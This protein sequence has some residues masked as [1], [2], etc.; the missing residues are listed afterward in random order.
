M[1]SATWSQI[2]SHAWRGEDGGDDGR[3][4]EES[5]RWGQHCK[6]AESC[7]IVVKFCIQIQRLGVESLWR[8]Y[9]RPTVPKP[10]QIAADVGGAHTI[11]VEEVPELPSLRAACRIEALTAAVPGS[12]PP[13]RAWCVGEWTRSSRTDR[14]ETFL[15]KLAV[16]PGPFYLLLLVLFSKRQAP[17]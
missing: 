11:T 13:A 17:E 6:V 4:Y 1:G 5:I 9:E 10:N 15:K 14:T 7:L 12:P 8:G 2:P 16:L 3:G